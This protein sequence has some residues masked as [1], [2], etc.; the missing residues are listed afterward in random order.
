MVELQHEVSLSILQ[1]IVSIEHMIQLDFI[2]NKNLQ[3]ILKDLDTT[4]LKNATQ[5]IKDKVSKLNDLLHHMV[6]EISTF[7]P[8]GFSTFQKTTLSNDLFERHSM[9]ILQ[10]C[11][12]ARGY[13]RGSQL[14]LKEKSRHRGNV[15]KMM[16]ETSRAA[17]TNRILDER[18]F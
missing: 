17:S 10:T 9:Q 13:T 14:S 4:V 18:P 16:L 2:W 8:R 15:P 12:Q 11:D 3:K 1:N 6:I 5:S 7:Q